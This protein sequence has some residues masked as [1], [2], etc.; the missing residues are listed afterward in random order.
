[1][2]RTR[3]WAERLLRWLAVLG[4][5][6]V[7]ACDG[8]HRA[9][10]VEVLIAAAQSLHAVLPELARE[11]IGGD[12]Q[13]KID[14]VYGGSGDL[15]KRALDGAPFD[16]VAFASREPI[17]RLERAGH[18]AASTIRCI[19]HN[20]IVLIGKPGWPPLT[21][22]TIDAL[23]EGGRLA[24]GDPGA[25]P[26]GTYAKKALEALGK[27][28]AL[29]GRLVLGADVGA[30]LAYARR[31]EVTAAIVYATELRGVTDVVVLDEASG[32]WAPTPEIVVAAVTNA[33]HADVAER[34]LSFSAGPRGQAILAQHGF[35]PALAASAPK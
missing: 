15:A 11:F 24:I 30:V 27:W 33:A 3:A 23:P 32:P 14:F 1:M 34:F 13:L 17:E 28:N 12:A 21:F 16:G 5:V 26:A 25:V 7:P 6:L 31:G 20:R 22:S 9:Q 4:I 10:R 19:A 35:L 2:A 8:G 29:E 18:L